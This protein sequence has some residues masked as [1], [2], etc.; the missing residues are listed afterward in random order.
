MKKKS[1]L[2]NPALEMIQN[3]AQRKK[4]KQQQLE[5]QWPEEQSQ[6]VIIFII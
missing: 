2:T 3:E 6:C 5:E 1:R 4:I